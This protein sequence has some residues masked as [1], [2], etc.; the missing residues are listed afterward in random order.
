MAG[1]YI[2]S[3]MY[4]NG[5]SI[6][7]KITISAWG[8]IIKGKFARSINQISMLFSKINNI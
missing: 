7:N 1:E 6:S 3:S 5:A 8:Y 4:E 2:I